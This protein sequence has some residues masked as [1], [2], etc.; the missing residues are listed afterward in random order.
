MTSDLATVIT[1]LGLYAACVII[2]GPNFALVSRLAFSGSRSAAAG[3]TLGLALA[4]TFYAILCMTGL[5]LVLA[6]IGWLAR[7]VQFAGGCFLVY[8][9]LR[10]W[11]AAA[12]DDVSGTP[13]ATGAAGGNVWPAVRTGVV[14]NLSNPKGIAFFVGLYAVAIPPGTSTS[15]KIAILVGGF[16]LEMLWYNLVAALLSTAPAR[17]F[18]ARFSKW[19]GRGIGTIFIVFGGRLVAART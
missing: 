8:L 13:D 10:A 19:I 5:A 1:V 14:V 9:G 7:I 16:L 15:A 3:A 4:A 17:R 2:P 18:Y 11:L 6:R 12:R